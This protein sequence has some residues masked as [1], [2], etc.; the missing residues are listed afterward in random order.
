MNIRA[1]IIPGQ[2]TNPQDLKFNFINQTVTIPA[3]TCPTNLNS[4][5]SFCNTF[6]PIYCENVLAEFN[7][8]NLPPGDFLLYAP[9]CACYAPRTALDTSMIN[10]G[11]APVCVMA[12]CNTRNSQ[13]YIDEQKMNGVCNQTICNNVVN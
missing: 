3:N 5:S 8:Q 6:Y 1:P 11:V 7:K 13:A 4:Q 9:E 2:T 10:S 12:D